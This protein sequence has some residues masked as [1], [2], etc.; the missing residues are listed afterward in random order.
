MK[1]NNSENFPRIMWAWTGSRKTAN[2][3]EIHG[4]IPTIVRPWVSDSCIGY[5]HASDKDPRVDMCDSIKSYKDALEECQFDDFGRTNLRPCE[6][7]RRELE[8]ITLALNDFWLPD[9][10][11]VSQDKWYP[12]FYI[13]KNEDGIA[14]SGASAGLVYAHTHT[15]PSPAAAHFGARLCFKTREI[16]K[17]AGEQFLPL[18]EQLFFDQKPAQR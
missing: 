11:D 7:A 13:R 5:E 1:T 12:W 4:H 17:Y 8:I 2:K 18:Y 9:W 10:N 16:A 6:I 14:H 3:V 15:T